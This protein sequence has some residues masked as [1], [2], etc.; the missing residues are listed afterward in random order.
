MS[1]IAKALAAAQAEMSN[2]VLNKT[3]PHFKSRYA[4]LA[5]IRDAVMPALTKHG[6]AVI[7]LPTIHNGAFVLIT[8]LRHGGGEIIESIYPLPGSSG[9]PQE[10]G[11]A[12]TYARRYSLAAMCGISAEEDDDA[13]AAEDA[14]RRASATP[15]RPATAPPPNTAPPSGK[16]HL[17]EVQSDE[18]G[19]HKWG[20]WGQA[21]SAAVRGA[22]TVADLDAWI[23]ANSVPLMHL[24]EASAKMHERIK[25]IAA[26][27]VA[28]LS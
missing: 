11:S 16:P 24:A 21:F 12:I 10:I 22:A 28:E 20:A 27:R 13:N 1:E 9:K 4:D 18:H 7:Q 19:A 3:N 8:H 14:A 17:I 6:I 15:K 5:A 26:E 2:A 25:T 23:G